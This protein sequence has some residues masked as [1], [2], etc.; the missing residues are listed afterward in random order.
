MKISLLSL[1]PILLFPNFIQNSKAT[2]RSQEEMTIF[3]EP[4]EFSAAESSH[5]KLTSSE[6]DLKDVDQLLA[7]IESQLRDEDKNK[8]ATLFEDKQKRSADSESTQLPTLSTLNHRH[9]A[10][11]SMV[12]E[13]LPK[14]FKA[15]DQLYKDH[16]IFISK[17]DSQ[18]PGSPNCL[19]WQTEGYEKFVQYIRAHYAQKHNSLG[20][21]L[22]PGQ[23]FL[24]LS[25]KDIYEP[26]RNILAGLNKLCH[27]LNVTAIRYSTKGSSLSFDHIASRGKKIQ[28][29]FNFTQKFGPLLLMI[30]EDQLF[31]YEAHKSQNGLQDLSSVVLEETRK[32]LMF[33]ENPFAKL[34]AKY[35]LALD[36]HKESKLSIKRRTQSDPQLKKQKKSPSLERQVK[37]LQQ[38]VK[39][40]K[41]NSPTVERKTKKKPLSP[42]VER[43]TIEFA[44]HPPK[45][46]KGELHGGTLRGDKK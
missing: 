14:F 22:N 2:A 6:F 40:L 12:V 46:L 27:D 31:Y 41:K 4:I 11:N 45:R 18:R 9:F 7:F 37:T 33:Q 8:L 26:H 43:K 24:E 30:F 3:D 13:R 28:K 35:T 21:Y 44:S 5:H 29:I 25:L 39:T 1:I 10:I 38:E 19:A 15:L 36:S 32:T 17:K 23:F 34:Y 20:Q 42:T 16:L